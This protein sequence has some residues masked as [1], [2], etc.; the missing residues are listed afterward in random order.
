MQAWRMAAVLGA[1]AV[2]GCAINFVQDRYGPYTIDKGVQVAQGQLSKNKDDGA[3]LMGR[4]YLS[5]V[6]SSAKYIERSGPTGDRSGSRY[7]FVEGNAQC[8]MDFSALRGL[9]ELS[10]A[11]VLVN[12]M[13]ANAFIRKPDFKRGETI[14]FWAGGCQ[15]GFA[16]GEGVVGFLL[17]EPQTF[18]RAIVRARRG[19][20]DGDV[21]LV[22][23]KGRGTTIFRPR[24]LAARFEGGQMASNELQK[25]LD[26]Q[27][28]Q[29]AQAAAAGSALAGAL[30]LKG[31]AAVA[32]MF[33]S[34]GGA[35]SAP[36]APSDSGQGW[37]V[38][39]RRPKN[40]WWNEGRV[41]VKCLKGTRAGSTFEV[42]Y[43]KDGKTF[44]LGGAGGSN[45]GT[46]DYMASINCGY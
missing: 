20:P 24:Q 18:H 43:D 28:A 16:E 40:A 26:Q 32:G 29:Q 10:E 44:Y 5:W 21:Y 2:S 38:G 6:D 37:S 9:F 36:S 41:E 22:K 7:A 15:G 25:S 31:A 17:S 12:R 34:S 30:L 11:E 1:A 39:Q 46:F 13:S 33:K 45:Y 42:F 14:V 8:K 23:E 4:F 3:L 27:V 35:S 19:Q